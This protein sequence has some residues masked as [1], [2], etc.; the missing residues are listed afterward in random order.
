MHV[1]VGFSKCG[2]VSLHQYLINKYGKNNVGR[3]EIIH[4]Y[5]GL[6]KFEER[7]GDK[8]PIPVIITRDPIQRCWSWYYY[9]GYDNQM[10]Y[11]EFVKIKE[12]KGSYGE[13]NPISISNYAKWMRPWIKKYDCMFYMLDY[14]KKDPLFPHLNSTLAFRKKPVPPMPKHY[15]ELTRKL[16][17]EEIKTNKEPSWSYLPNTVLGKI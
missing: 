8:N 1:V 2:Q 16:L 15:Q 4:A 3:D 9:L 14:L 5:D 12:Y 17:C 6:K 11:E 13:I 7:W 10:P